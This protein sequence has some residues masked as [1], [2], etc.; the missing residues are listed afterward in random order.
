MKTAALILVNAIRLLGV[1]L[2]GLGLAFWS[3]NA[4]NLIP[5]HMRMGEILVGLLWV[6][7]GISTRSGV[8]P[9]LALL[10][11]FYGV[12][13]VGFG[14]RMGGLLPGPAHELIR[15]LHL[16]FGLGAIGFA[17]AIGGRVKRAAAK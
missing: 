16:L 7:A 13:V 14:M 11:M 9:M 15:V 10:A 8:K 3:G 2:I 4:Y 6:L 1:I 17:E 5:V 12:F